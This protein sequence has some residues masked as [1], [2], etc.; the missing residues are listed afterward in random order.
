MA[1]TAHLQYHSFL[2]FEVDWDH[3]PGDLC[4][5]LGQNVQ[6][7]HLIG[8]SP[9]KPHLAQQMLAVS[10]AK[11]IEGTAA[12]EG[13]QID[14]GTLKKA[15]AA[16]GSQAAAYTQ[17]EEG[18]YCQACDTIRA[19]AMA[20]LC[21]PITLD[22]LGEMNRQV[23]TG[24]QTDEGINIGHLR[25]H[26]VN[27]QGYAPPGP[28]HLPGLMENFLAW[29]NVDI[30]LNDSRLGQ[31]LTSSGRG[32]LKA[33]VGHLYFELIHPFGDGNGRVGR[34]LELD[35]LARA[36]VPFP[37]AL[38]LTSYYNAYKSEYFNRIRQVEI[39]H[40]DDTAVC[41][42]LR[43]ALRGL[44]EGASTHL[45]EIHAQTLQALWAD[46]IY[47]KF[48]SI[49]HRKAARRQRKLALALTNEPASL[50]AVVLLTPEIA[51]A[52]ATL[53]ESTVSQDLKQLEAMGIA[54]RTKDG[55]QT[56]M[57]LMLAFSPK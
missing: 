4:H 45:D 28:Q 8:V 51:T 29:L 18:N 42:F 55:W 16:E 43:F 7:L 24:V 22:S 32:I 20:N 39:D 13:R 9:I 10:L 40:Q 38:A 41:D 6:S 54:V 31:S 5:L 48:R 23:L 37:S 33:L 2:R 3:L 25:H 17:A 47:E 15:I 26:M 30:G 34:L 1:Y 56:N 44:R 49:E 35:L 57:R 27:V 53:S 12:I 19:N 46:Y 36:G 21:P 14:P 52:Y 11:Y 50:R